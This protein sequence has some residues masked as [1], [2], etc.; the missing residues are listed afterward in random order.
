MSKTGLALVAVVALTACG[1]DVANQQAS[2]E[3]EFEKTM[4]GAVL[5]GKFTSLKNDNVSS[6]RYTIEK[7]SKLGGDLWLIQARIQY[8]E[9]VEAARRAKGLPV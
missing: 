2:L 6:D 9:Q 7:V 3:A 5:A 4:T 8:G 1:K